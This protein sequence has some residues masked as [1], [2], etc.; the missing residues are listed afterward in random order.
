MSDSV[1]LQI[2]KRIAAVLALPTATVDG[3]EFTKPV[4]LS[5]FRSRAIP[6]D[7]TRPPSLVV[8]LA[9]DDESG[10][11]E[12][13]DFQAM[14]PTLASDLIVAVHATATLDDVTDPSED[15]VDPLIVWADAAICADHTLNGT[16]MNVHPAGCAWMEEAG[17]P[18]LARA[19]RL[20]RI[21]T[22]YRAGNLTVAN[23]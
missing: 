7:R 17:S 11:S 21:R 22:A 2:V 23:P 1:P 15:A 18:P 6:Q 19:V 16:A 4:G 13:I 12:K 3:T 10:L 14:G 9:D 8:R 20:Y 5:V